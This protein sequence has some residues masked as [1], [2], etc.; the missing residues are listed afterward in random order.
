MATSITQAATTSVE[1][2]FD[3]DNNPATGCTLTVGSRTMAGVE[4]ALATVATT[5][6]DT[7]AVGAITRR[8]CTAGVFGA[9][10][11]VSSGGW[12]VGMTTGL[13]GSDLI[14]TFIPLADLAGASSV[15]IGAITQ[16]DSLIATDVFPL[17]PPV[18]TAAASIPS[19]S[20]AGMLILLLLI[21]GTGWLMRRY[22]RRH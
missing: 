1:I 3:I 14:E 19:L 16:S 9:P 10:V 17:L 20:P 5:M 22:A 11:A 2:G 8:T 13:N 21:G 18:P 15:K 7:G 6:V 12:S 4:V